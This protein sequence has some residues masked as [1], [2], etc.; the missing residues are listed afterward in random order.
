V[1]EPAG[2]H[3]VVARDAEQAETDHEQAGDRARPERDVQRRLE[4]ALGRLGCA[5]VR[6]HGDVHA[7]EAGGRGENRPDQEADRG[8]PA[9]LVVEAE[10]EE[11]HDRDDRDRRVLAA[12]IGGSALLYGAA[13][14]L[15]PLGAGRLA[16]QPDGQPDPVRDGDPGADEGEENSVVAEEIDRS[17]SLHTQRRG[18]SARRFSI[19]A[20]RGGSALPSTPDHEVDA[21]P[22]RA[23]ASVRTYF[24]V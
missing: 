8:A 14:L 15:H 5:H 10:Q 7:D 6:A 16:Q 1:A 23:A 18:S 3:P 21:F 24:K 11:G 20:W 13:D 17:A 22:A 4:A 19:T 12:Q 9:E 2:Q